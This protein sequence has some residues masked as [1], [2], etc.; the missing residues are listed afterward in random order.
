M[1]EALGRWMLLI[2][3]TRGIIDMRRVNNYVRFVDDGDD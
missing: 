2:G 1:Y 3:G